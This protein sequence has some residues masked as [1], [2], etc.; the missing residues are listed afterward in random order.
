MRK[1]HRNVN[2]RAND[3]IETNVRRN[4]AREGRADREL[5]INKASYRVH[6][7]TQRVK[8]FICYRS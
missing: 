2:A 4:T 6:A 3:Q 1:V 5:R 7:I 8:A